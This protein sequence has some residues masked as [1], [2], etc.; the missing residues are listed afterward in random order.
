LAAVAGG[1]GRSFSNL[2]CAVPQGQQQTPWKSGGLLL[3]RW[4]FGQ[5]HCTVRQRPV[6]RGSRG[7]FVGL[8][9]LD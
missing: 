1:T 3:A 7:P 8:R 5:N 6:A 4:Q 9:M 2:P